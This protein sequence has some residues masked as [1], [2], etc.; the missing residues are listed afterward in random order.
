MKDCPRKT[1]AHP[2]VK[3]PEQP[4][5]VTMYRAFYLADQGNCASP[6]GTSSGDSGWFTLRIA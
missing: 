4:L 2:P 6:H 5:I 3:Q 1:P